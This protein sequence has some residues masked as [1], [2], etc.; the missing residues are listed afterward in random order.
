MTWAR[1]E[2]EAEDAVGADQHEDR[3][4]DKVAARLRNAEYEMQ[5]MGVLSTRPFRSIKSISDPE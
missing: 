1:S 2:G 4:S 5:G 3:V